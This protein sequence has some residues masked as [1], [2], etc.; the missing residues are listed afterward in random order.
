MRKGIL[1]SIIVLVLAIFGFI[2]SLNIYNSKKEFIKPSFDDNTVVG[3]P[4]VNDDLGYEQLDAEGLYIVS[5]CGTPT[6]EK[7]N[8]KLYFTS[9]KDNDVYL[10]A[11]IFKNDK[12]VGESGLIKPGEYIENIKVKNIKKNDNI[13]VKIMGYEIDNYYSAGTVTIDLDVR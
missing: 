13:V 7:D 4:T 6:I 8:L 9:D 11:R 10:K 2:Y 1:M 12:I 5:L 3:I